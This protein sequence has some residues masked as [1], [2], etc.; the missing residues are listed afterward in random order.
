MLIPAKKDAVMY[1]GMLTMQP[2]LQAKGIGKQLLAAAERHAR[3]NYCKSIEMTV[4]SMRH[5]LIAWYNKHAY[6]ST[7]AT[8]PFPPGGKFGIAKQPLGFVVMSKV[9]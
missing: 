5:E 6:Q 4:I 2:Q 9:P 3:F 7:G 8:K 1:L